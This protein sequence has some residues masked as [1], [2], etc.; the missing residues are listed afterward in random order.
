MFFS[1]IADEAGRPLE[2]QIRA[3]RELGWHHIEIRNVNRKSLAE[4]S[5]EEFERIHA[6]LEEAGMKVS[7]FAGRIAN[8][9]RDIRGPFEEDVEEL[10]SSIPR[11]RRMGTPFIRVMSY[12]NKSG[13]PQTQWRA[14]AI[15][16]L[17]ELARMAD[18][19]GVTLVHENCDGWGGLGPKQTLELLAEVNS[20]ALKLVFDTG[21]S[22]FHGLDSWDYYSQVKPHIVYVHVKDWSKERDAA[23][24]PGEGDADVRRILTD[25][26]A[27]GYDSGLS[28]EPH[29]A[30]VVH[31]GRESSPEVMYRTYVEYGRRFTALMDELMR[32][33]E[34]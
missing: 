30:A 26:V 6:T 22:V 33:T 32:Q 11:M 9:A 2:V 13:V 4:V 1:G 12:A 8:W 34:S 15:R 16:R 29:M 21:N 23:A 18:G 7:C 10:Q 24:F 27:S 17:K 31:E 3:H 5:E 28:I 14:E 19:G 25:L 20:P